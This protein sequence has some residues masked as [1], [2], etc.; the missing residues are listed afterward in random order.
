MKPAITRWK[1]V[2]LNRGSLVGAPVRGC[3]HSTAPVARS[4]KFFTVFGAW[5]PNSST[6]M[7]PADVCRVA[8]C[9]ADMSAAPEAVE[10]GY[11][12]LPRGT[13][14]ELGGDRLPDVER[15]PRR[16]QLLGVHDDHGRALHEDERPVR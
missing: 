4:T 5:F 11:P 7:S 3:F 10:S 1:I 2:P 9:V 6:R 16:V 15:V 8:I 13:S 12:I 14:S